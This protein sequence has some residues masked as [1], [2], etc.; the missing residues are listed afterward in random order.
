MC[1][2]N[3]IPLKK[4]SKLNIIGKLT[5]DSETFL[6]YKRNSNDNYQYFAGQIYSDFEFE[7]ELGWICMKAEDYLI[8]VRGM[9]I[10]YWM[11]ISKERFEEL[12][13]IDYE[14][15]REFEELMR[16]WE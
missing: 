8:N 12:Y 13:E 7:T 16:K 2:G 4:D 3:V 1:G 14:K 10:G 9:G 11:P 5:K 15:T 6:A